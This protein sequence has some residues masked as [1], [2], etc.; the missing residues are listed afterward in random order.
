MFGIIIVEF[1]VWLEKQVVFDLSGFSGDKGCLSSEICN[2]RSLKI[3]IYYLCEYFRF[4]K[5]G[6]DVTVISL[7]GGSHIFEW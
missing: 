5:D 7:C 1:G 4:G 3:V 2:Y 6:G